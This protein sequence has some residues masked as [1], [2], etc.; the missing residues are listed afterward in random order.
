MASDSLSN[1]SDYTICLT[2]DEYKKHQ[3]LLY[4]GSVM[5]Q[6]LSE[7]YFYDNGECQLSYG[8]AL[9]EIAQF[10]KHGKRYSM[11][12]DELALYLHKVRGY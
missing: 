7:S 2:P 5:S 12:W 8:E 3:Q 6:L 1:S 9:S 4:I 10:L 11:L